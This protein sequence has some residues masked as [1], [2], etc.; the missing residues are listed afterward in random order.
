MRP[1]GVIL[2]YKELLREANRNE[3]T[4]VSLENQQTNKS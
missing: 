3:K 4:L 1:K 2:K